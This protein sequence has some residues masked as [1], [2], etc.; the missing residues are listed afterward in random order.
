[1]KRIISLTLCICLLFTLCACSSNQQDA[2][3]TTT[4]KNTPNEAT[5]APVPQQNDY[6]VGN[7]ISKIEYLK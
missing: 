3:E 2:N 1:M 7:K 5:T 6:S 4:D